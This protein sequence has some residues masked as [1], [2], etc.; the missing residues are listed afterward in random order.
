MIKPLLAA[1]VFA[2]AVSGALAAEGEEET[3][4]SAAPTPAASSAVLTKGYRAEEAPAAPQPDATEE[5]PVQRRGETKTLVTAPPQRPLG[6]VE[7]RAAALGGEGE[8][9]T[10]AG[11]SCDKSEP[12]LTGGVTRKERASLTKDSGIPEAFTLAPNQAL[13]VK[14]TAPQSGGGGFSI[15]AATN[16]RWEQMFMTISKTPCDFDVKKLLA[17]ADR[18]PNFPRAIPAA[19]YGY[20]PGEGAAINVMADGQAVPPGLY[21]PAICFITPGKTYYL[22]IR[23]LSTNPTRDACAEDAKTMGA[24]LKCGGRL[25]VSWSGEPP[26]KKK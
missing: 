5:A 17:S 20:A 11:I 6:A 22:N 1:L 19:C 23:T 18:G 12:A 13:S 15:I 10:N 7:R 25:T 14:F 16:A 2:L 21:K 8:A 3:A 24:N 26:E 4:P 9:S